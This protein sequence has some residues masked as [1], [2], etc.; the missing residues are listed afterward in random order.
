MLARNIR[1]TALASLQRKGVLRVRGGTSGAI[2]EISHCER[3]C[4]PGVCR[5]CV[6]VAANVPTADVLLA[7]ALYIEHDEPRFLRTANCIQVMEPDQLA[8]IRRKCGVNDYWEYR[9]LFGELRARHERRA[10]SWNP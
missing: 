4:I 10:R 6:M 1:P 2:Y 9:Y 7:L 8:R 5:L 3:V